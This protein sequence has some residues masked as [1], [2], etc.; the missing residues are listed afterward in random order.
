MESNNKTLLIAVLI[1]LLALV[2]FNFNK[3]S[4]R[5]AG[6]ADISVA[7]SPKIIEFDRYDA[8]KT[9]TITVDAGSI[10]VDK[11]VRLFRIADSGRKYRMGSPRWNLCNGNICTGKISKNLRLSASLGSGDYFF[12]LRRSNY[13]IVVDSNR[14]TIRHT[15]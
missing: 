13:D 11:D 3:I 15:G 9:I 10:G 2:A 5:V 8:A 14:F 6:D 12:R 4:G 7:V 1:I